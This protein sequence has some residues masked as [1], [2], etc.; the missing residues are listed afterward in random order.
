MTPVIAE[1]LELEKRRSR[2][3]LEDSEHLRVKEVTPS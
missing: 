1:R 2:Q 3:S